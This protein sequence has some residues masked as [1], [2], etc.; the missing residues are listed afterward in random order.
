VKESG[1]VLPGAQ[2]AAAARLESEIGGQLGRVSGASARAASPSSS[3]LLLP[4]G[5][6]PLAVIGLLVLGIAAAAAYAS[7]ILVKSVLATG[8]TGLASALVML[9]LLAPR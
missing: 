3:G 4:A 2:H 8:G 1:G 9:F 5:V 6:P 7:P